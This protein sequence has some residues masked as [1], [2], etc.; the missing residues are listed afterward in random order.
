MLMK[1]EKRLGVSSET[2]LVFLSQKG[3]A[4]SLA[5]ILERS[6]KAL[7]VITLMVQSSSAHLN[8]I[9]QQTCMLL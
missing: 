4:T 3:E 7:M 2:S 1:K 6:P 9:A 8:P 5:G